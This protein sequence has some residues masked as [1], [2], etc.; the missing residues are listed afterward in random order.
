MAVM[1]KLKKWFYDVLGVEPRK[2]ARRKKTAGR[3]KTAV[4]KKKPARKKAV[5]KKAV[6]KKA[7]KKKAVTR[8]AKKKKLVPA[9]KKKKVQKK[10]PPKKVA[11]RAAQARKTQIKAE[12]KPSRSKSVEAKKTESLCYGTITH[13]FPKVHAAVIRVEKTLVNGSQIRIEGKETSFKQKVTSLQINRIPVDEGRP[14]EDVGLEVKKTVC[15]GD[16]VLAV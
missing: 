15:V 9:P 14:G 3:K 7:A 16:R 2:K 10:I 6:K 13:Y 8:P 5:K 11:K 4:P 1:E 12:P